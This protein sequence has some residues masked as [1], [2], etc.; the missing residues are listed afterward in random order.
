MMI[1]M[2]LCSFAI[3]F[4][5]DGQVNMMTLVKGRAVIDINLS[6]EKSKDIMNDFLAAHGLTGCDTVVTF[7]GIW[8]DIALEVL[9][10]SKYSISLLGDVSGHLDDIVQQTTAFIVACYDT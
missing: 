3:L 7:Y 2:Y 5:V 9:G 10:S 6:F 4:I 8:K 1:Q